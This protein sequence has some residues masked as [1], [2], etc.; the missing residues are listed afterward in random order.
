MKKDIA[1][2]YH[3]DCPDGFS[4]AWAA[5]KKFGD[6]AEYIG[7]LDRFHIPPQVRGKKTVYFIDWSYD[8]DAF[9]EVQKHAKVIVIDHHK[10]REMEARAM[11]ECV[12]DN[13]RSAA[14]LA[15]SYF[16]PG[17]PLPLFLKYVEDRDIWLWKLPNSKEVAAYMGM[18]A[19][20]FRSWSKLVRDFEDKNLRKKMIADGSLLLRHE[21]KLISI[22]AENARH[23]IFEGY[24]VLAV[25][26]PL[27]TSQLGNTLATK[28]PPFSI[29]WR[30]EGGLI[31][32]SLRSVGNFD[33]SK[34]A[35]KYGGGGHRN[36]AGVRFKK[37]PWKDAK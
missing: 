29:V 35:A 6:K 20:S 27:F 4:G 31:R 17:K 24:K 37:I 21:D 36:A 28:H 11:D 19:F 12:F 33:V 8:V 22:V 10:S 18:Q 25:N 23:V 7:A 5:W 3:G 1:V 13:N 34:I 15:W 26:C 2:V 16:H 14:P 9:R 30:E 32:A